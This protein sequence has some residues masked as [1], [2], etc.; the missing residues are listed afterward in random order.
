MHTAEAHIATER[1]SRY[2]VQLCEHFDN[3]LRATPGL[4]RVRVEAG[5]Q[6]NLGRLQDLVTTHIG[7]FSR[8]DPLRVEWQ[9]SP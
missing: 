2:L 1:P 9:P 5:D 6:E 7:R 3:T 4:L 8:R